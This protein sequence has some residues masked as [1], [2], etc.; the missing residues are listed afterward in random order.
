MTAGDMPFFSVIVP[1]YRCAAYLSKC[2]GSLDAQTFREFE[3]LLAVES[4]PDDS[5]AI[6]RAWAEGKT[7]TVGDLPV[8]GGVA[9]SR[10]WG[11]GLARGRYVVM[12][13]GDDWLE[14]E[15]LATLA[16]AIGRA[17][18][19]DVVQFG[20]RNV[21]ERADGTL[22]FRNETFNLPKDADGRVF[23]AFDFI[24]GIA[25]TGQHAK[26]YA[27]LSVC[28]TDFLREKG[29]LQRVEL[30]SEDSEW[31]P[32]VW[33][34]ADRI[35]FV[36]KA[37]YNYRRRDGGIT[38]QGS[39][40]ILYST[41]AIAAGLAKHFASLDL[42]WDV[43]RQVENDALAIFNWYLFNGLYVRRF[44]NADRRAALAVVFADAE[45]EAAYRRLWASASRVKRWGLPLV[46]FARRTGILLPAIIYFR[47]LYYPLT[48]LKGAVRRSHVSSGS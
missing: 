17:D 6:C 4:S 29:L 45:T 42:P 31:S 27:V 35:A 19:P 36:A 7:A 25:R 40:K 3:T 34:A 32:R 33:L 43:R 38:S 39:T 21:F 18:G 9:A 14:P 20:L 16:E 23:A 2:L 48:K 5:L 47:Y 26:S 11:F 41:A 44:T 24:R 28:R 12:L 10:N 46:V 1:A 8:S 22:D 30:Q 15:A 13:D 37:L